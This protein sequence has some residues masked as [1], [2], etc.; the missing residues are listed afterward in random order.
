[1][2]CPGVSP[3]EFVPYME[4]LF[5]ETILLGV[6]WTANESCRT[7]AYSTLADL[8]HHVRQ[9]LPLHHL[10]TAVHLFSKNIHDESQ[11]TT[12]VLP[13]PHSLLAVLPADVSA[14]Q[15]G[16]GRGRNA[17]GERC[18]TSV[19]CRL[20]LLLM[21]DGVSERNHQQDAFWR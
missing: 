18:V 5:D 3:A 10:T 11:P 6:G 14:R 13:R 7:L 2:T 15:S 17:G 12:S 16:D 9:H 8:I 4:K 1:M 21:R 20:P 19:L